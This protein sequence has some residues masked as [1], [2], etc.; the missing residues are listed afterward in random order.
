MR[1]ALLL[2][3]A[4]PAL[5]AAGDGTFSD[6][7]RF[8]ATDGA[9]L[10]RDVC[11]ECHMPDG[12]GA[13]GAARYPSLAHDPRLESADYA[14]ALVLRGSGAM[15]PFARQLTD[16]QIAGI[17]GFIRTHFANDFAAPVTADAVGSARSAMRSA[18]GP[19]RP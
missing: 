1:R 14:I 8:R 15:P 11:Q 5:M 6:P 19:T 18:T 4:A 3:C 7:W 2:A 13:A 17:V 9:T 10:Y 12:Q 16:R